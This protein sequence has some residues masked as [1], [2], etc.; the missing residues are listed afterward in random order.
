MAAARVKRPS[1]AGTVSGVSK[2]TARPLRV[3][4]QQRL[5]AGVAQVVAVRADQVGRGGAVAQEGEVELLEP[6]SCSSTWISANMKAGSVLG[7]IGTHSA[8]QAR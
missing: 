5:A 7:L 1:S 6:C 3:V 4:P 2:G 8:E